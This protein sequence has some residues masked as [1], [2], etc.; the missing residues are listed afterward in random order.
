MSTSDDSISQPPENILQLKSFNT[1]RQ[2]GYQ[3]LLPIVPPNA[4]I[5]ARSTLA[6]ARKSPLGKAPGRRNRRGEWSSFDWT[7]HV[8]TDDDLVD[9]QEMGA[10]VGIRTG[11]QPNS[12]YSLIGV[13]AD[14]LSEDK[15]RIVKDAIWAQIGKAP[16]RVGQLPKAMYI[17]KL[18]GKFPYSRIDFGDQTDQGDYKERVEILTDGKQFVAQGGHP[19]GHHYTWPRKLV[20]FDDL[21]IVTPDQ[22]NALL[23]SLRKPLDAQDVISSGQPTDIVQE[24][25]YARS[26]AI[27]RSIVEAIPNRSKEFGTRE[28]YIEF[29]YAIKA[30]LP[31]DEFAAFDIWAEWCGRWDN[32]DGR[33]NETDVIDS[34]WRRMHP[35]FRQ[36]ATWLAELADNLSGRAG[37]P[38]SLLL[39][40]WDIQ[41]WQPPELDPWDAQAAKASEKSNLDLFPTFNLEQLM[42][43][44]PPEW[45]LEKHLPTSGMGFIY[46]EPGTYKSFWALSLA[47]AM[48]ADLPTFEGYR[49][50][51]RPGK[52][53]YMALEGSYDLPQRVQAWQLHNFM[54]KPPIRFQG[55]ETQI[56]LMSVDHLD[57][58]VRTIQATCE[59]AS[60]IFIDTTSRSMPGADENLQ[61][62]MSLYVR[63][64]DHLRATFNCPVVGIH[65]ASKS[66]DT[67]RGSTVLT[68]AA[69][70]VF[71]TKADKDTMQLTLTCVKQKAGPDNWS[72]HY[73][74]V[75]VGPSLAPRRI[76]QTELEATR[77][78]E[79]AEVL[80]F[81]QLRWEQDNPLSDAKRARERFAPD[82][83]A[84][85][86]RHSRGYWEGTL[87]AW[88][89]AGLIDYCKERSGHGGRRQPG[90][91]VPDKGKNEGIFN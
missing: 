36:G 34:D 72:D 44:P 78:D 64:C 7:K 14:C 19:N 2:M 55:L 35:P 52:V 42:L 33:T 47:L 60:I 53:F 77:R 18:H 5:S 30:S 83:L 65:H 87:A 31:Q 25:L 89:K 54:D 20:D 22:L 15:A 26:E 8:T 50:M 70:F 37:T 39:D 57:R 79:Q 28:S 3:T 13:D 76:H 41:P 59:T 45:L 91:F 62:E 80:E 88:M 43:R 82:V 74:M 6:R 61:K 69:D 21:P 71:Q 29:G 86:F 1:F 58:L 16:I 73:E 23:T 51:S 46:G 9:W 27:L 11:L 85:Q 63:A 84:M 68:G 12:E 4:T 32:K 48:A 90:Y 75:H 49:L 67:I 56:N 24:S 81:I 66:G 38:S 17:F 10:S 40:Q